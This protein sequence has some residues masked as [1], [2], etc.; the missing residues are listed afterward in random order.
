MKSYCLQNRENFAKFQKN[1]NIFD[2]LE[3]KWLNFTKKYKNI[4]KKDDLLW[5]M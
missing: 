2:D 5:K 1:F 3:K 4:R